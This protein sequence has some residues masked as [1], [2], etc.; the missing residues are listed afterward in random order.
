MFFFSVGF[1]VARCGQ[2]KTEPPPLFSFFFSEFS[3]EKLMGCVAFLLTVLSPLLLE[4]RFSSFIP[5]LATFPSAIGRPLGRCVT[6]KF[7][8]SAGSCRVECCSPPLHTHPSSSLPKTFS[9]FHGIFFFNRR[10]GNNVIDI[11]YSNKFC[12]LNS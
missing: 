6:L 2:G 1:V 7:D 5:P 11:P 9:F 3:F 10:N 12:F 4:R 8:S